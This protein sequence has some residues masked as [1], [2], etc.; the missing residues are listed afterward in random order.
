MRRLLLLTVAASAAAAAGRAG[1]VA[2]QETAATAVPV[3]TH[4]QA[5]AGE[6]VYRDA[7]ADCHLANLRGD[8]EAPELAGRSF[9]RAWGDV[10]VREL[11][12]NI[13]TTMP[14]DAPES[15]SDEEYRA[16]VAYII[17]ENGGALGGVSLTGRRRS[18]TVTDR[19]Y[20]GRPRG[21]Q[22]PG[23]KPHPRPRRGPRRCGSGVP[24]RPRVPGRHFRVP[25]R[26]AR[27]RPPRHRTLAARA[28]PPAPRRR[29]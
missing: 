13:R 4:A 8:F 18:C 17:R 29:G 23:A 15:L 20:S 9:R 12:E 19:R 27:P 6:A 14:E 5:K 28:G 16:I 25:R 3:Y 26:P 22:R 7:C 10:P 2:G 11:L 21:R 1:P 24:G